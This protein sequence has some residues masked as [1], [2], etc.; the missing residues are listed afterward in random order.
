MKEK[1]YH[2]CSLKLVLKDL[3]LSLKVLKCVNSGG[4][5]GGSDGGGGGAGSDKYN[6][7]LIKPQHSFTILQLTG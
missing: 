2:Y 6:S 7:K 4:G 5:C 1:C 3:K